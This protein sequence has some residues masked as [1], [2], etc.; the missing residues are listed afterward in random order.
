[1]T[2]SPCL[3]HVL[4][5]IHSP[6]N[7]HR[8]A[9]KTPLPEVYFR[10]L[11]WIGERRSSSSSVR[12]QVLRGAT[13]VALPPDRVLTQAGGCELRSSTPTTFAG[14]FPAQWTTPR[15]M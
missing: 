3:E 12:V 13:R 5:L 11:R 8:R 4:G 1:M 15:G 6:P 10:H 14:K 9:A 7:S 2:G